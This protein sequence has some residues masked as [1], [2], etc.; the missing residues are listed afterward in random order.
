MDIA[1]IRKSSLSLAALVAAALA[2]APARAA[3]LAIDH[4]FIGTWKLPI[5]QLNC[6]ETYLFLRDGTSRVTSAEEISESRFEISPAPSASGFYRWTDTIVKNN[7]K[8]DC[9]GT[10]TKAGKTVTQYVLFHHSGNIFFICQEEKRN[11][12]FGPFY[13]QRGQD[14]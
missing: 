3:D 1:V 9:S 10:V 2:C 8:K 7:G 13:R 11:T 6:T 14:T 12:C 5:A 4:P